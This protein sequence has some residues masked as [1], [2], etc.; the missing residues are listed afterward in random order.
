MVVVGMLFVDIG[1]AL[2]RISVAD[3]H[4]ALVHMDLGH[5]DLALVRMAVGD[6]RLAL[7]VLV[8]TDPVDSAAGPGAS[9]A[10][11]VRNP[12]D[13]VRG[14][15][16][17]ALAVHLPTVATLVWGHSTAAV[18]GARST[19]PVA[20]YLAH[21]TAAQY[22]ATDTVAGTLA[23]HPA[24][25]IA[26][27]HTAGVA[28][29]ASTQAVE[30]ATALAVGVRTV[31]AAAQ[32]PAPLAPVA[33]PA[34]SEVARAPASV[35][36]ASG[37]QASVHQAFRPASR[38]VFVHLLASFHP[39]T[40]VS[41]YLLP[42]S[43]SYLPLPSPSPFYLPLLSSSSPFSSQPS[44]CRLSSSAPP[45]LSSSLPHV[46]SPSFSP[47]LQIYSQPS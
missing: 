27:D 2:D 14:I 34:D 3:I 6:M 22:L 36:A 24:A 30:F 40:S 41:S 12:T 9:A 21:D 19:V 16:V 23:S 32:V 7:V 42:L 8:P 33:R 31:A 28:G 10:P 4:L 5:V 13:P 43:S 35:H 44:P 20:E 46:S 47:H 39:V 17:A 29:T 11:V 15:A 1:S 37:H 18:G 26:T 38:P 45:L 25:G